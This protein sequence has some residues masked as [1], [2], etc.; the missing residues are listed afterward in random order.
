MVVGLGDF[1]PRSWSLLADKVVIQAFFGTY[2]FWN[3]HF[4]FETNI[5]I[6]KQGSRAGLHIHVRIDINWLKWVNL[7][8][9]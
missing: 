4:N 9:F 6:L 3:Q 2:K 1:I 5:S 8:I 7:E